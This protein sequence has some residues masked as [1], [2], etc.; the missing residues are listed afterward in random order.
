MTLQMTGLLGGRTGQHVASTGT[1]RLTYV[2]IL[3]G[4][5]WAVWL[6]KRV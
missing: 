6:E 4:L 5:L 3:R 1:Q 2:I